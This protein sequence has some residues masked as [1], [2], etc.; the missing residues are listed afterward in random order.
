MVIL[1]IFAKLRIISQ[2][3]IIF[4]EI[5]CNAYEENRCFDRCRYVGR[6]RIEDIP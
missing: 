1:F 6:E 2:I 5:K 3:I 4:A